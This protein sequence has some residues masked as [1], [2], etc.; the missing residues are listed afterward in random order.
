[1]ARFVASFMANFIA[2]FMASS[3]ASHAQK[4]QLWPFHCQTLDQTL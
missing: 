2:S 1:M 4:E 3:S